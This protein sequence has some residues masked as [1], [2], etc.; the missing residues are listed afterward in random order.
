MTDLQ[1]QHLDT[2]AEDAASSRRSLLKKVAL[3]AAAAG[4]AS[5]IVKANPANAA[6][7]TPLNDPAVVTAATYTGPD[8]TTQS[9]L[10]VGEV[11]APPPVPLFPAAVGGYGAGTKIPNG[12]HG[13]TTAG[14]GY[15]VVAANA[16]APVDG[17]T[18]PAALAIGSLGAHARFI[19]PQ[20]LATA[21][22]VANAPK[23][24]GP[25]AGDFVGGE[26]YV[27]D[28]YNLWFFVKTDAGVAPVKLA[29]PQ[30][31]GSYHPIL[32]VPVRVLDTR[33]GGGPKV[34]SGANPTVTLEKAL[35]GLGLLASAVAIN[36]TVTETVGS[37]F[38]SAYA[39]G[40]AAADIRDAS[41]NV[42]FSSIN[43]DGPDQNR[44]NLAIV[45]VGTS[46]AGA[47]A[48]PAITLIAGGSGSTHLVID[49]VGYYL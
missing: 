17:A 46:G 38:H 11:V 22:G 34:P 16:S 20:A 47:D 9:A 32:P 26:L 33:V 36:L 41:G 21:A 3:G 43:W 1:D 12:L 40:T 31:A 42:A 2:E 7:V 15:G 29:G 39:A 27:D 49:V 28:D 8:L 25:T 23:T 35:T 13:S 14:A 30:A 44:A 4:A 6:N 10:S 37:G 19:P 48:K 18:V 45:P 24:V 5:A